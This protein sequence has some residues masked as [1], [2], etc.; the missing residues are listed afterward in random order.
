MKN[1]ALIFFML[2][3]NFI[4]C[5]VQ[6][7]TDLAKVEEKVTKLLLKNEELSKLERQRIKDK[8]GVFVIGGLYNKIKPDSLI[9]GIYSISRGNHSKIFFMIYEKE[10]V[11]I[12]DVS[13]SESLVQS[14]KRLLEFSF[15]K[16]YCTEI[17]N[18]YLVRLMG[19][20]Y[21]INKNLNTKLDTNC[22]YN[23][24]PTKSI[25]N[26]DI[27]DIKLAEYL[28]SK[29][30]LKS[31]EYYFDNSEYLLVERIGIYYGMP[32]EDE[33]LD[34]GIY[35]FSNVENDLPKSYYLIIHRKKFEILD[36]ADKKSL[37]NI[38][39][40][41]LLFGEENEYCYRKTGLIIQGFIKKVFYKS[42]L[43]DITNRLP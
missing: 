28:I 40:K 13:S 7:K 5:Q 31:L 9:E 30:E 42:C 10:E 3:A 11:Q 6:V 25:Y 12:L 20:Y 4:G 27:L 37:N 22:K 21:S 41:V 8:E 23:K 16:N 33:M 35:K 24:P 14:I 1:I 29:K 32:R 18:D 15:R 36:L 39:E 2:L 34:T 38:I 19:G 17:I 26:L 43:E